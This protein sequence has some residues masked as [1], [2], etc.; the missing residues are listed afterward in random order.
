MFMVSGDD[1]GLLCLWTIQHKCSEAI[2]AASGGFE[3][4]SQLDLKSKIFSIRV[5]PS[6]SNAVVAL[7]H[8]LLLVSILHESFYPH[9]YVKSVLDGPYHVDSVSYCFWYEGGSGESLEVWRASATGSCDD[10]V[11]IDRLIFD[12]KQRM[13][14]VNDIRL[15]YDAYS[16]HFMLL[17]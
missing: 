17:F 7:S 1:L 15:G 14:V 3:L 10:T 5:S 4:S 2:R 12:I 11:T 8:S 16:L 13:N 9:M 6:G